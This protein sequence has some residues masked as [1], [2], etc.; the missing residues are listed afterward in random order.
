[1]SRCCSYLLRVEA[2]PELLLL[3]F[4]HLGLIPPA[5]MLEALHQ[6]HMQVGAIYQGSIVDFLTLIRN[7][8]HCPDDGG[9][10]LCRFRSRNGIGGGLMECIMRWR[11]AWRRSIVLLDLWSGRRRCGQGRRFRGIVVGL[12]LCQV[13]FRVL[14][15]ILD[16]RLYKVPWWWSHCWMCAVVEKKEELRRKTTFPFCMKT[17]KKAACRRLKNNMVWYVD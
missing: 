17:T 6:I 11:V 13:G 7:I 12:L 9:F 8:A 2:R 4:T 16:I 1:M 15:D 14:A 3:I 10:L 5:A